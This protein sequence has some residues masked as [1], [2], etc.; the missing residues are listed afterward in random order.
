M[1]YTLIDTYHRAP[2]VPF[3]FTPESPIK[4]KWLDKP[5]NHLYTFNTLYIHGYYRI[6]FVHYHHVFVIEASLAPS[7]R[8]TD[9]QY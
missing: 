8:V 7:Q 2:T 9:G 6:F 3:T 4:R 1:P 5:Y